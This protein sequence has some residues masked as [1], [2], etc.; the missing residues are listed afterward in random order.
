MITLFRETFKL[1]MALLTNSI[2]YLLRKLP[3]IKHFVPA[4]LYGN[5][6]INIFIII[7]SIILKILSAL[8]SQVLYLVALVFFAQMLQP[9]HANEM[10]LA[11]FL[12]VTLFSSFHY[13]QVF[14]ASKEKYYAV[15]L[16]RIDANAYALMDFTKNIIIKSIISILTILILSFFFDF[17]FYYAFLYVCYYIDFNILTTNLLLNIHHK[18]KKIV[19][20]KLAYL[21]TSIILMCGCILLLQSGISQDWFHL[22]ELL[23]IV[24]AITALLAS[25]MVYQQLLKTRFFT[26]I[27]KQKLTLESV[28]LSVNAASDT[29]R[30][31]V[32]KSLNT[33]VEIDENKKGFDY[34]NDIFFS[35]HK[36]ILFD[37]SLR[38]ALGF[39]CVFA[40]LAIALLLF[41]QA[42]ESVLTII[43]TRMPYILIV[44]YFTNRG[45]KVTLAMYVNCDSSMLYYRFYRQPKVILSLFTQRLKTVM[46]VNLM[47][48]LVISLGLIILL[49]IS[50]S[51]NLLWNSILLF[52]AVN[53]ISAFFSVHH[54]VLYY[55]LQ[56]YD[57]S[58]QTRGFLF[59]A[60]NSLT[61]FVCY[62]MMDIHIPLLP[63]TIVVIIFCLLYISI[64]LVLVYRHAPKTFKNN[65]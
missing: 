45:A 16:M 27:Y 48:S 15:V 6:G 57:I 4:E 40:I 58:L 5:D 34:F 26:S 9:D 56:P 62:F 59:N 24:I 54:L 63:F 43:L 65:V 31:S 3:I 14:H 37:S 29:I 30:K 11:L 35:R 42:H 52:L 18:T 8:F 50:S 25:I 17:P 51:S 39:A 7:L 12:F 20:D 19:N 60:I 32:N 53:A 64:S 38:F 46:I 49:A 47:P 41:P 33:E 13:N 10:V 44:M 28:M 21:L 22:P 61:Y 36:R 55:L 1:N 2:I 23:Y